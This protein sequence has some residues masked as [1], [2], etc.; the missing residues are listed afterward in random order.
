MQEVSP[1]LTRTF[2]ALSDP[3]RMATIAR[4]AEGPATV[5]EL[6]KPFPLSPAGYSK[7]IQVLQAAGLVTKELD[8]RRHICSLHPAPL[9]AAFDWLSFYEKFWSSSLDQLGTFLESSQ[10]DFEDKKTLK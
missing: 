4:L 1:E 3:V 9:K 8:G 2:A 10:P 6:A 7:H 5:G